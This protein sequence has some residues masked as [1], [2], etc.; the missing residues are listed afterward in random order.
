MELNRGGYGHPAYDNMYTPNTNPLDPLGINQYLLQPDDEYRMNLPPP[1]KPKSKLEANDDL[2]ASPSSNRRYGDLQP[3]DA[4]PH[5]DDLDGYLAHKAQLNIID[6]TANATQYRAS[7]TIEDL[8]RNE[9]DPRHMTEKPGIHVSGGKPGMSP[10]AKK[11]FI[12]MNKKHTDAF[13]NHQANREKAAKLKAKAVTTD[14]YSPM[15]GGKKAS[16]PRVNEI[17]LV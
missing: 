6:P 15:R 16:G 1:F 5:T 4:L 17:K 3:M 11:N 2:P 14:N 13:E 8:R 10:R 7:N 12:A 9:I